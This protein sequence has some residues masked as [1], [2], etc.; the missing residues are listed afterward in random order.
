[1]NSANDSGN[2]LEK[3]PEDQEMVRFKME[4]R[5]VVTPLFRELDAEEEKAF[6]QHAR[7][8]YVVGSE[9]NP[10]NHPVW[11]DEATKMNSE[12]GHGE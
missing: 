3:H 9:I 1:M 2:W 8:N 11:R 10:V 4:D 6:R 12:A 7:E 5:T